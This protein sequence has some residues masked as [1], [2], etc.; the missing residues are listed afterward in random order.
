MRPP[1]RCG[2]IS[3]VATGDQGAALDLPPFEKGGP[4]L[5]LA[6]L[7]PCALSSP[8]IISGAEI[9]SS[10]STLAITVLAA[11]QRVSRACCK[12]SCSPFTRQVL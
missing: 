5:S 4:K 12:L 8:Y 9:F 10:P 11:T 1:V 6:R 7:N 3:P 2:G